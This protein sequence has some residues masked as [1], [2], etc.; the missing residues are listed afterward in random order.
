MEASNFYVCDYLAAA[1]LIDLHRRE[2][3]ILRKSDLNFPKRQ[4]GPEI[5]TRYFDKK[6]KCPINRN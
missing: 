5:Y 2:K 1:G 4:K 3:I 6:E